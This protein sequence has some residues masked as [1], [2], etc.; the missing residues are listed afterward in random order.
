[1]KKLYALT[2][3]FAAM[4][5]T[6]VAQTPANE[7]EAKDAAP[8]NEKTTLSNAVIRKAEGDPKAPIGYRKPAGV[9]YAGLSENNYGY[10]AV[11]QLMAPPCV[12]L[13]FVGEWPDSVTGTWTYVNPEGEYNMF[14]PKLTS[15]DKILRV[16]YN[17]AKPTQI[18]VP[19]LTGTG[20][21]NSDSTFMSGS[22]LQVAKPYLGTV[23]AGRYGIGNHPTGKVFWSNTKYY[24]SSTYTMN[25]VYNGKA[26]NESWLTQYKNWYGDGVEAVKIKGLGEYFDKPATPLTLTGF[27]INGRLAAGKTIDSDLKVS[28]RDGEGN[29]IAYFIKKKEECEARSTYAAYDY[30]LLKF[31][32]LY[33]AEGNSIEELIL[34]DEFYAFLE[35]P[36]ETTEFAIYY[37]RAPGNITMHTLHDMTYNGTELTDNILP[38]GGRYADG[39]AQKTF[40]MWMLSQFEW[41]KGD[42][43]EYAAPKGGGSIIVNVF[44]SKEYLTYMMRE[45][46]W[47]VTLEDGSALPSWI[48]VSVEDSFDSEYLY[49]GTSEVKLTVA[50]QPT[51]GEAREATVKLFYKGDSH[52]VKITQEGI[53]TGINDINVETNDNT[54]AYNLAGQRVNEGTTGIIIKNG[55]KVI[56][57]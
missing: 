47:T 36:D 21:H 46:N 6:A 28:I 45:P 48:T 41:L 44:A 30:Y 38:A 27:L 51:D 11:S 19:S 37:Y 24:N 7:T 39:T 12:E 53:V 8:L 9:Y 16:T 29:V 2:A 54:P 34:D 5:L 49:Q 18:E 42:I 26:F 33:D 32:E 55:K 31:E 25:S 57:K 13:T 4:S 1:M 50:A 52:L 40:T 20:E 43:T 3:M 35:V 56:K 17:Y 23:T 14:N 22:W 10:S 15:T